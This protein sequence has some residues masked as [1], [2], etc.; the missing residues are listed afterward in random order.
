MA[1][2]SVFVVRLGAPNM[3]VSLLTSLPAATGT[4]GPLGWLAA[5]IYLFFTVAFGYFLLPREKVA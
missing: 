5:A 3:Q 4:L 1:F 2:I